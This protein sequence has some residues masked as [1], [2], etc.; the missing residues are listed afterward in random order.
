MA[1]EYVYD[2]LTLD[3]FFISTGNMLKTCS[4]L[5][6]NQSKGVELCDKREY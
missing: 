6:R 2:R 4:N 5:V 1:E 3:N